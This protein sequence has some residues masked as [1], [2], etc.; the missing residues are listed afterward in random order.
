MAQPY[1]L[2]LRERAVAAVE[3][4][5]GRA[6]VVDLF[7]LSLATLKRRLAK[8]R[9]GESLQAK[10]SRPGPAAQFGDEKTLAALRAQLA[11]APDDRLRDHC[12]RWQAAT[13][14]SVSTATM[15]RAW[16]RLGWTHKKSISPAVSAAPSSG[17]TG[18]Q[19]MRG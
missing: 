15:H 10:P 8:R 1:S 14:K 16:A 17:P 12:Q 13:G 9:A 7:D 4:G 2:D 19:I 18:G 6:E 5:R 3:S 11:A